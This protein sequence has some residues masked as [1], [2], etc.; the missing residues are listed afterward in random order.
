LNS[1]QLRGPIGFVGLAA[2]NADVAR[3][4]HRFGAGLETMARIDRRLILAV[5]RCALTAQI[6]PARKRYNSDEN[7]AADR[8][9]H[10]EKVA[11]S[12]AAERAWLRG[13]AEEPAWPPFPP[14]SIYL[15]RGLR[16][17]GDDGRDRQSIASSP[18]NEELQPS[19]PLCG[20]G[21]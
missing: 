8:E 21:N 3:E 15:N 20:S 18:A 6:K 7:Q 10:R 19:E 9:R 4:G 1:S 2:V 14:R 13:E 16:I 11:A 12:I 5:L 17:G